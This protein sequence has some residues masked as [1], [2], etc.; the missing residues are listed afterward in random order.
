MCVLN[1]DEAVKKFTQFVLGW[2]QSSFV[3]FSI[4]WLEW[5][6]VV[7]NFIQN[8]FV[9]FY[10]DSCHINMHWKKLT[11]LVNFCVAILIV[12]MEENKRHFRHMMLYYFKKGKNANETQKRF[13]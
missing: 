3:F 13:T 12:E 4:R 11:K 5:H 10:C 2:P 6:L 7:F 9:R 1:F 8:N